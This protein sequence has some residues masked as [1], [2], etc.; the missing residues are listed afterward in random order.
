MVIGSN[1]NVVE[2]MVSVAQSAAGQPISVSM[3]KDMVKALPQV[4]GDASFSD[5]AN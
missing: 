3:S 5:E 4:S 1:T 2:F